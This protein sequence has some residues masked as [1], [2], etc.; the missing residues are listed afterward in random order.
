[1]FEVHLKRQQITDSPLSTDKITLLDNACKVWRN[2]ETQYRK[3][4]MVFLLFPVAIA[5]SYL[6]W[7]ELSFFMV[8]MFTV[9]STF[10]LYLPT[11]LNKLCIVSLTIDG[12]EF[13]RPYNIRLLEPIKNIELLQPVTVEATAFLSKLFMLDRDA[14][15]LDKDIFNYLNLQHTGS[16]HD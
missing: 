9:Y 12:E 7:L 16:N 2:T 10:V 3:W 13:V 11:Y 14:N 6:T 1:M 5:S 8:A 15:Q 4:V